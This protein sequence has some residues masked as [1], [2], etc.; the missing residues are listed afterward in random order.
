MAA[1]A[2]GWPYVTPTDHPKDFPASSQAL[3]TKAEAV[4][5]AGMKGGNASGTTDGSGF[6]TLTHNLGRV[7]AFA[8]VS[9][10]SAVVTATLALLG[11]RVEQSG[12][13]GT[14]FR[15]YCTRN[16]TKAAFPG[17][18]VSFYFLVG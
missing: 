3:A 12:F 5:G 6:V 10:T 16:D 2:S 4:V 8:V 1:T 14:T 15:V 7:P 18:A 9:P 11:Y 13:T 17:V